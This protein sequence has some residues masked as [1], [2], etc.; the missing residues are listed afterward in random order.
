MAV[1]GRRAALL[2]GGQAQGNEA[3][4]R[5]AIE[6]AVSTPY[7]AGSGDYMAALAAVH[8]KRRGWGVA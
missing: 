8:C 3:A 4:A 5:A 7:G 1:A 6:A 2:R